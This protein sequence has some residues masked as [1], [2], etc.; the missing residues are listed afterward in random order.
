MQ[1]LR[2]EFEDLI[3]TIN[4]KMSIKQLDAD[5]LQNYIN[6]CNKDIDY[7]E[8]AIREMDEQLSVD[9]FGITNPKYKLMGSEECNKSIKM[10]R[11]TQKRLDSTEKIDDERLL[12]K[13]NPY[14]MVNIVE[15]LLKKCFKM[16]C[17]KVITK[18][19]MYNYEKS[20]ERLLRLF[21][22]NNNI[23]K[24]SGVKLLKKSLEYKY[25]EL[26]LQLQYKIKKEQ[27]K[28]KIKEENRRKSELKAKNQEIENE[29]KKVNKDINHYKNA[30]DKLELR[31]QK[32]QNEDLKNKIIQLKKEIKDKKKER[33]DL[34][35]KLYN[36]K[37]GYV[38]I[39]SNIGSFGK[40]VFKIGVTRRINPDIRIKE[41]NS[42]SVPF[43]FDKHAIIFSEDAFSLEKKLHM[44]F[45][46]RKINKV[47]NHK[48]FYNVSI[49]DIEKELIKYNDETIEFKR[50]PDAIDYNE[51]LKLEKNH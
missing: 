33:D 47:N 9:D 38:Y 44:A 35:S 5:K 16:Q 8:N 12:L 11:A 41:L 28:E 21:E 3:E 25:D 50:N 51:T 2:K 39:I 40:N 36:P 1:D 17:H 13:L 29:K 27:E 26:D 42:A 22:A 30:L 49:D 10:V 7:K 14:E 34:E 23:S 46:D 24:S 18:V 43:I 19:T 45:D 4:N 15:K 48:E 31:L 20:K 37:A 6:E 32:E